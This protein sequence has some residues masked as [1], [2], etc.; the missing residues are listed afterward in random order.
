MLGPRY[1]HCCGSSFLRLRVPIRLLTRACRRRPPGSQ[2]DFVVVVMGWI[3][4]FLPGAPNVTVVR[5]LRGLRV[6]RMLKV[7]P[8]MPTFITA[9]FAT[10][11]QLGNVAAL[12][13]AM[14]VIFGII[15]EQMFQGKLHYRCAEPPGRPSRTL[16]GNFHHTVSQGEHLGSVTNEHPL[17]TLKGGSSLGSSTANVQLCYSDPAV[18]EYEPGCLYMAESLG[19]ADFDSV[20]N[21]LVGLMQVVTLDTWTEQMYALIHA[22]SPFAAL[23]FFVVVLFCSTF[24]VNVRTA[25]PTYSHVASL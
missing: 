23:Y 18:C 6:L 20:G 21:A 10:I 16:S 2:L 7:L 25:L 19:M 14:L 17:R 22:V 11:P 15:G 13:A 8:G 1:A 9:I 3:P 4:V 5:A 24:L 12:F